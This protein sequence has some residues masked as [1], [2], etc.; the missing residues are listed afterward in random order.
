MRNLDELL[1][2][3]AVFAL[4]GFAIWGY[5]EVKAFADWQGLRWKAGFCFLVGGFIVLGGALLFWI[6]GW[7]KEMPWLLPA[8]FWFFTPAFN[9]WARG[10]VLL[11][12][13]AFRTDSDD[14]FSWGYHPAWYGNGWWQIAMFL[15]LLALAYGAYK[16]LDDG[17]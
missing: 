8:A 9:D 1:A 6:K 4:I 15:G 13:A 17:Y 3:A 5:F 7:K 16:I 14:S 10:G 12:A 2:W 11:G